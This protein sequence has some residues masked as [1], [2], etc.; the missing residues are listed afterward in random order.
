MLF[1][2]LT[3]AAYSQETNY[4]K[5]FLAAESFFL[6]EEFDEALPIYMRIH[7]EFPENDNIN[8]KIGICYLNDPYQ[9]SESIKYL[10]KASD[11]ITEKYRENSFKETAAPQDVLFYL[12]NAYRINNQLEKAK[13]YYQLFLDRIDPDVYDT[14]LIQD[15]IKAC[16][17]AANMMKKTIDFTAVNLTETIN[18][19]FSDENPIV[20]G[21]E[22]RLAFISRLQ[23]YDAVF[24]SEKIND[25]WTKPRNILP[26]LG[27][28]GDVYPT[29]FSWDGSEMYVYRN[30]EFIGNLYHTRLVDGKWTPLRKLN[31]NINTRFWESHASVTRDGKTLYFSSNRRG[32]YGGLD[33]YISKR[34]DNGEWGPAVNMGPVVNTSYNDDTPFV[35][36]D[37]NK[38]FFSSY[39]HYNMGGYDIFMSSRKPDGSWGSPLNVGFPVNTTD[40]DQFFYPVEGGQVAYYSLYKE[41]EGFGKHDIYRLE[42]YSLDNPRMYPVSGYLASLN[43]LSKPTDIQLLVTDMLSMDTIHNMYPSNNGTFRFEVPKGKYNLIFD[44]ESFERKIIGFEIDENTPLS[45]ITLDEGIIL[46]LK[47]EKSPDAAPADLLT[48]R[49]DSVIYALSGEKVTIHFNMEK[50]NAAT[51]R[52]FHDGVLITTDELI[53]DRKR[54]EWEFVPLPGENIIEITVTDK[55]GNSQTKSVRVIAPDEIPEDILNAYKDTSGAAARA[56]MGREL[57]DEK[58]DISRILEILKQNAE[59][60]LKDYLESLNPESSGIS[61]VQELI[62][63]LYNVQ[64][65]R[66]FSEADID[67][68]LYK[69]GLLSGLEYFM[70]NLMRVSTPELEKY[71][72]AFDSESNGIT[73]PDELITFLFENSDKHD[74]SSGEVAESVSRLMGPYD[75]DKIL[76]EFSSMANEPLSSL[77]SGIKCDELKLYTTEDLYN[78]LFQNT[79]DN[80]D[81]NE[82]DN[83]LAK[84][85]GGKPGEFLIVLRKMKENSEGEIQDFLKAIPET[86]VWN[87]KRKDFY[88]LLFNAAG[89]EK[90]KMDELIKLALEADKIYPSNYLNF[91]KSE[92]PIAP[93]PDKLYISGKSPATLF[94]EILENL[95]NFTIEKDDFFVK[96]ADYLKYKD[97]YDLYYYMLDNTVENNLVFPDSQITG[98]V[99]TSAEDFLVKT[100]AYA[101][102]NDLYTNAMNESV[103]NAWQFLSIRKVIE[104]L[105]RLAEGNLKTALIDLDPVEEGIHSFEDIVDNLLS[106]TEAC[107]YTPAEVYELIMAYLNAGAAPRDDLAPEEGNQPPETGLNTAVKWTAGTLLSAGLLVFILVFIRRRKKSKASTLNNH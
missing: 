12:G 28:D 1:F 40:N 107:G 79:N 18:T 75:L 65:S 58:T 38:I 35:T 51:I 25:K 90:I 94:S 78:H 56:E 23:F 68:M 15:Q 64:P 77:L 22:K 84:Y 104:D 76:R 53:A 39:G 73:D 44:G 6:F 42:V 100:A 74:F 24:Y 99:Y 4:R 21:N 91:L 9:K 29:S 14:D 106:K 83:L 52:H 20:S 98:G 36:D 41:G 101:R 82:L 89:E 46:D 66:T 5:M 2:F 43:P 16:D 49:E 57:E 30:D 17:V 55:N 11:N 85:F 60:D 59:P 27:V 81:M 61:S 33:I 50:G 69:S 3:A 95:S 37:G 54:M 88:N 19:R 32:G 96:N 48:L 45:G 80:I 47:K 97:I 103:A 92:F 70:K 87:S 7:R 102:E 63:H 62:D 34:Q 26:E 86:E 93:E 8:Y 71:L 13:E 31:T 72:R 105:I 10:E 67:E